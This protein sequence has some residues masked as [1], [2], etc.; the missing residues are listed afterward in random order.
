MGDAAKR[1]RSVIISG[2]RVIDGSGNPWFYGDVVLAGDQID[3]IV[4]AG[5]AKPASGDEIVDATGHG[6]LPWLHRHP[7][8]LHHPV[9]LRP[10][11]PLENHP[12]RD[13]RDH[14]RSLD[15]L[16]LRRAHR[17]S[18]SRRTGIASQARSDVWLALGKSWTRFGDWLAWLEAQGVSVNVGSFIGG[19]TVR[20]WGKGLAMGDADPG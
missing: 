10:P 16:P 9:P 14:G 18:L 13:D 12:G 20:E 19:G 15:S 6:C 2:A 7:V 5:T 17:G 1:S 4:P 11:L 8:A 3:G